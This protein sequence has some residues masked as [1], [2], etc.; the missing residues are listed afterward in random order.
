MLAA[1]SLLGA[2][3]SASHAGGEPPS[4]TGTTATSST[5]TTTTLPVPVRVPGSSVQG[6]FSLLGTAA[7]VEVAP[8]AP[9]ATTSS[10][11]IAGTAAFERTERIGFRRFG[12]G[13]DL[14]MIGGEDMSMSDWDPSFLSALAQ[15]FTVTIFDL[16]GTGFSTPVVGTPTLSSY[17]DD[18]AGLIY[19]LGLQRPEVL[20]WGLGGDVALGLVESHP[21]FVSSLVLVDTPAGGPY[22][23][24]TP[25]GILAAL[26][27]RWLSTAGL[28]SIW[29]TPAHL[30][31]RADWLAHQAE[32]MP[33]ALSGDAR[34]EQF[35]VGAA[36]Q[37]SD[38][39]WSNLATVS[40][41]TLVISG[42]EDPI[43]PPSNSRVLAQGI[44][45]ARRLVL[46]KADYAGLFEDQAAVV[47]AVESL[48]SS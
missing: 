24:P 26:E 23:A 48:G 10:L 16:P 22:G 20:G 36:V 43:V 5:T 4:S 44:P 28:A 8:V 31:A 29:F 7:R 39:L 35:A 46:A 42:S 6:K 41:P 38:T 37:A 30:P 32:V 3:C 45:G 47:T 14:L 34:A 25:P 17:V 2:A 12:S 15:H 13:P 9:G 18:T 21:T 27:S 11:P 40:V 19:A 1:S 33:D